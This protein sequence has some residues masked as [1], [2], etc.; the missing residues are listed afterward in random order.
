MRILSSLLFIFIWFFIWQTMFFA[1]VYI[2][3]PN[4]L[5]IDWKKPI[6]ISLQ[7]R[8]LIFFVIDGGWLSKILSQKF[9]PVIK[10]TTFVIVF[11]SLARILY[12]VW[13]YQ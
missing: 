5:L 1:A 9:V 7:K 6:V 12:V 4:F 2:L 3:T 10:L 11:Y 8:R 13:I